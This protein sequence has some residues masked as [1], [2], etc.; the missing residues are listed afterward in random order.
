MSDVETTV[1]EEKFTNYSSQEEEAGQAT[2]DHMGKHQV[3]QEAE[4]RWEHGSEPLLWF[5]QDWM[6]EEG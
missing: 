5:L 2:R 1:F 4:V 3:S 6:S